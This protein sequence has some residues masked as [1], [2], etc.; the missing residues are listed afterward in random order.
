MNA[1]I[2]QSLKSWVK[3][4]AAMVPIDFEYYEWILHIERVD[5]ATKVYLANFYGDERK[6]MNL[7]TEVLSALHRLHDV[8]GV[9][10]YMCTL[11][12]IETPQPNTSSLAG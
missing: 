6:P 5:G 8:A 9:R 7:D 1:V 4:I 12:G 11:A 3:P 2:V 10:N